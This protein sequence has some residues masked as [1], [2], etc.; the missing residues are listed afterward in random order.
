MPKFTVTRYSSH[1]EIRV[2]EAKSPEAAG[3]L[4]YDADYNGVLLRDSDY[5]AS[6]EVTLSTKDEIKMAK[7]IKKTEAEK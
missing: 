1:I 7:D 4:F 3:D 6:D 2:I 5:N